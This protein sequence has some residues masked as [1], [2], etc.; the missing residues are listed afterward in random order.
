MLTSAVGAGVK[1]GT[2]VALKT[3]AFII[4][5]VTGL[6]LFPRV[7]SRRPGGWLVRFW[8][9]GG[10][11]Q[12]RRPR[13]GEGLVARELLLELLQPVWSLLNGEVE[14]AEVEMVLTR[15]AGGGGT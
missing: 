7:G 1:I 14:E 3:A 2:T 12:Y 6:L 8:A 4:E 10:L 11:L 9:C 13:R 15:L 5:N